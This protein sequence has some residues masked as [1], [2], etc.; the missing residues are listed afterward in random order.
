LVKND[1]PPQLRF[2]ARSTVYVKS[3][4][5]TGV[6]L[7]YFMFGRSWIVYVFPPLVTLGKSLARPGMTCPP[8]SP[9]LWAYVYK[10][11]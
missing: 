2:R 5:L 10:P 6:P 7:E 4:A 1:L 8:C 9:P 3:L 11:V